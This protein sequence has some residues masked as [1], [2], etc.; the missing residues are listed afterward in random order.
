MNPELA[1]FVGG[2]GNDS[3]WAGIADD[4]R[5]STKRGVIEDFYGRKKGVHVCM[6][7]L[8]AWVKAIAVQDPSLLDESSPIRSSGQ[9]PGLMAK[10]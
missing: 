9:D 10:C 8:Q 6:D 3:S 7:H 5:F 2:G 4:E 1:G